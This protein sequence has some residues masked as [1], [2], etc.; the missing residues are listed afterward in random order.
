MA[1]CIPE[2]ACISI[3]LCKF[4]FGFIKLQR[5]SWVCQA[6]QIFVIIRLCR[7]CSLIKRKRIISTRSEQ[8]CFML[9]KAT[10]VRTYV[11]I[12]ILI[13]LARTLPPILASPG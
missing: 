2:F 7:K 11:N 8:L 13:P 5:N 12:F 10:S 1:I 9:G 3:L 4:M 6:S